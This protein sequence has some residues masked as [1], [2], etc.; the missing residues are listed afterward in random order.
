MPFGPPDAW[1]DDNQKIELSTRVL[2]VIATPGHTAGHIVLRDA[3][4]GLLFAGDHVLPHITPSIGLE[5][6]P[7]PRPLRSYLESL[8]LVRDQ[9]D[10]LLLPAHGPVT[11]SVHSR[12]DELL[13]HH[14]Q[15][16]AAVLDLV[17][18]GHRTAYAV[19]AAMPWTRRE[20]RLNDLDPMNRM[21]AI[22]EVQ[23]HL[24]VL[25]DNEQVQL[26][27]PEAAVASYHRP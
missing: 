9:P 13:V 26:N 23:A 8:Q 20:R 12:V 24:D 2:E 7:E 17:G 21:M 5:R 15:R 6:T 16:L 18:A 11:A 1:L 10:L 27:D 14:E 4:A 19:A 25:A 3:T 22:L